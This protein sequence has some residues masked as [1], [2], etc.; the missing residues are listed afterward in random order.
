MVS[1]AGAPDSGALDFAVAA[2]EDMPMPAIV[3]TAALFLMLSSLIAAIASPARTAERGAENTAESASAVDP[4]S[5]APLVRIATSLG[6]IVVE[7]DRPRAPDTVNNFLD[8]VDASF[9]DDTLFHRV[10]EGFMIQGGG[11]SRDFERRA[12]RDPV[13]NEADNG[14][15][16]RRYT[17][18]M[19]RTNAPHS[20]TAQF[21]INTADNTN[22]DHTA[23][24]ARGWGYTVFGRVVEGHEVVDSIEGTPTG[25]GGPFSRDAPREPVII[26]EAERV[27][28][29]AAAGD[30]A[31]GLFDGASGEPV[32]APA[33]PDPSEE[34]VPEEQRGASGAGGPLRAMG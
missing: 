33:V 9:Y 10:I 17:I 20:A 7:L 12:T 24:T 14:L 26:L 31:D 18:A 6:D 23:P 15:S 34:P 5:D 13:V 2:D 22:L 32:P 16:N 27:S 21:F 1:A 8:Y 29:A 28:P 4:T 11:F 25:P 3:P 19:A 30:A